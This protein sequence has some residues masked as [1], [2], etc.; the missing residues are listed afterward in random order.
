LLPEGENV[1]YKIVEAKTSRTVNSKIHA[2]G[3]GIYPR[4]EL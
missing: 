1:R 3:R 2:E 4:K